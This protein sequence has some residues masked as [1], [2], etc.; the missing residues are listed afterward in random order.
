MELIV[1][2]FIKE[3]NDQLQDRRV[4]VL[5]TEAARSHLAELGHDPSMGA[6]PMGRIIQTEIKDYIADEL[7]FGE[8]T[9]GGV[10]TVDVA[11][12]SKK[13][14]KIPAVSDSGEFTFTY[15]PVGKKQ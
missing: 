7:L 10:V 5:L 4:V 15:D 8:L 13:R 12:K 14:K 6:R 1:D 2:K 11:G 9:K 3:L